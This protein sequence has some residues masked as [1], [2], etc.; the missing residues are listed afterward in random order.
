MSTSTEVQRTGGPVPL[1]VASPTTYVLPTAILML[2]V[3]LLVVSIFLPYWSLTLHAP[4]YPGGLSVEL[5]VNRLTGDVDEIDELNHYI[6][7]REMREAAQTERSFSVLAIGTLG[8]L[9]MAAVF[10]QSRWAA[11]LAL[12]AVVYPLVFLADLYFWLYRFGHTLDPHAALSTSIKPFT[13]VL[14]G[15]GR[16]G[17][18]TTTAGLEPGYLLAVL[19][20]ATVVI[21][22]YFHRRAYKPLYDARHLAHPA[23]G[24][25]DE[26]RP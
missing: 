16:V 15:E 2:G 23:A 21:G 25:G 18:F 24:A 14:L 26:R 13:P 7:M 5:Y 22:L 10:I 20:A 3:A 11:L 4:Q 9:L 1:P 19:G 17:Q 12:P 6:G 8:L